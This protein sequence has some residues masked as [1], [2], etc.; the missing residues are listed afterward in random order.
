MDHDNRNKNRAAVILAVVTALVLGSFLFSVR[1]GRQEALPVDQLL[2]SAGLGEEETETPA[3]DARTVSRSASE[4]QRLRGPLD[5]S[6]VAEAVMPSI[7]AITNQSV[8]VVESY[9]YGRMEIPSESAG[10]GIIIGQSDTELLI[11][12]NYH[13]LEDADTITVCFSVPAEDPEAVL[14]PALLKGSDESKDLAVA[15]VKLEDISP[16][17]YSRIRVAAL[18]D[19]DGL[20]VGQKAV[21]IGNALGYGQ[22]VTVGIISA[23][24]R[25][26]TVDTAS[27]N[28]IQTDAAINFGNSGGA[29]LNETGQ[30]IGINSAKATAMGAEGMGYAIPINEAKP[31]LDELMNRKTREKVEDSSRGSLGIEAENVSQEAIEIYQIPTGAFVSRVYEGS[32]AQAAGIERGDIIT[33]FD[34]VRIDSAQTLKELLTYYGAG[35]KAEVIFQT[36]RGG[37]YQEMKTTVTLQELQASEPE[38]DLPLDSDYQ[39][40]YGFSWY[41]F[42]W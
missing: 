30:V 18:G 22:S 36:S 27:Q 10:S 9:F 19:S 11:A 33:K 7:V 15:A 25:E 32:A 20:T 35:E 39:N 24:D 28:F 4:G 12:T 8:Q 40:P 21:A 16:E 34:G 31:V 14:A 29:L 2:E 23:L 38:E 3:Q 1:G 42:F 5:V 13:V 6:D 41:D 17:V 26:L 37:T